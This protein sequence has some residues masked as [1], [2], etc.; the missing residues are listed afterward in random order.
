MNTQQLVDLF[1]T[2]DEENRLAE[3]VAAAQPHWPQRKK[4]FQ[5]VN[6]LMCKARWRPAYLL[7]LWM[8]KNHA[9]NIFISLALSL[10]AIIFDKPQELQRG[11]LHLRQQAAILNNKEW[12]VLYNAVVHPGLC[13]IVETLHYNTQI[14][15]VVAQM[16]TFCKEFIPLFRDLMDQDSL[17]LP[18]PQLLQQ[19]QA[20]LSGPHI[21]QP[22][23]DVGQPRPN[24]HVLCFMKDFYI[25]HRIA[26]AMQLYGWQVLLY[27][28]AEW[29]INPQEDIGNIIKLCYRSPVD[30]M[31]V[32]TDQLVATPTQTR[33]YHLLINQ[34]RRLNPNLKVVSVSCDAWATR[35]GLAEGEKA[36]F[37]P[38]IHAIMAQV[39]AIWSSDSPNLPLW[40]EPEF[41][42]KILH[43]HIPHG[44]FLGSTE[45]PFQTNM[46]YLGDVI[47]PDHWHRTIWLTLIKQLQLPVTIKEHF[48]TKSALSHLENYALH[49]QRLQEAT[50]CLHFTRKQNLTCIVTHRSFEAPISGALLIQECTPDMH[51]FFTPG[52]HYLEFNSLAEL[53]AIAQFIQEEP[54]QADAIRKRGH[55]FAHQ[56]Y[57]DD[58]LIGYLEKFLWP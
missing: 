37:R 24:R 16:V 3:L 34:L 4:L 21:Q 17:C 5:V 48:Y 56:W 55:A 43:A 9:Q 44:G 52:E 54:E 25:L 20:N 28:T 19:Q 18:V 45:S 50:C 36:R 13:K 49:L 1:C 42:E 8:E 58:K 40:E 57:S 12:T 22:L 27:G 6:E 29:G 10:G 11:L 46:L 38:D 2:L 41:S 23:P 26:Q 31:V 7:A 32:Y 15:A 30:L 51:R 47:Y 35:W 53:R 39:D 14:E 33:S